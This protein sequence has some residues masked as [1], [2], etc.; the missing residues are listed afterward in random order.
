MIKKTIAKS[1]VNVGKFLKLNYMPLKIT[2]FRCCCFLEV[3]DE[4]NLDFENPD[5]DSTLHRKSK[6]KRCLKNDHETTHLTL[7]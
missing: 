4:L 1:A 3:S 2:N 7:R 5:Q 6:L